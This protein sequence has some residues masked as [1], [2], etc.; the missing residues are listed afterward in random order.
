MAYRYYFIVDLRC[1]SCDRLGTCEVSEHDR[2]FGDLDFV[3][4]L[5]RGGFSIAK[6]GKDLAETLF[7]CQCGVASA[8]KA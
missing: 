5:P 1:P 6:L 8:A 4:D 2:A 3:A 7:R